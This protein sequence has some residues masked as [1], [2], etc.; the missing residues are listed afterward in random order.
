LRAETN[1][2]SAMAK[3]PLVMTN[4][5][6]AMISTEGSDMMKAGQITP[7]PESCNELPL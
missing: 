7:V 5:I 6:K 4:S 3:K 2:I 1:A